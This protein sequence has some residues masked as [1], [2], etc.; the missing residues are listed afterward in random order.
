MHHA[1]CSR[2]VGFTRRKILHQTLIALI[3]YWCRMMRASQADVIHHKSTYE[4]ERWPWRWRWHCQRMTC[5]PVS[6]SCHC[7]THCHRVSAVNSYLLSAELSLRH[8]HCAVST[9]PADIKHYTQTSTAA[10]PGNTETCNRD[11]ILVTGSSICLQGGP[12]KVKPL[13]FCW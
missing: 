10:K 7:Q 1:C 11:E 6:V 9:A 8:R 3:L 2:I 12:A 4:V 13:T 5:W